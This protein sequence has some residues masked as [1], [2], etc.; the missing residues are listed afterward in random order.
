MRG[1][2]LGAPS[3]A[4]G[5]EARVLRDFLRNVSLFV[6]LD[7]AQ[8]DRV[9]SCVREE[10]H[11]AKRVIFREGDPVDSFYLV[12]DGLVT[13][14]R[15]A[16]GKPLQ[17][18]ARLETGGF[19]G[20]M[21]LLNEKARRFAS[22][23]TALPS[24][25][26]RIERSDLLDLLASNPGL[27]LKFRAEVVRRHGMNVSALLSLAGQRDVRIRLGVPAV[28]DLENGSRIEVVLENL[29]LGGVGLS[30]APASWLRGSSVRFTLGSPTEPG[31]LEVD[32]TIMWREDDTIGIAFTGGT[33]GDATLVYRALRRFLDSKR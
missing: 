7:D 4:A 2:L 13:V 24:V 12:R 11:P 33:L 18:L 8:L 14:F 19:F 25:L 10:H 26:W 31:I 17:V 23:R 20:E 27:E 3:L 9:E 30:R 1:C 15:E 32:G 29:S 22:A 21:G 16:T 6:D 28:A 5:T